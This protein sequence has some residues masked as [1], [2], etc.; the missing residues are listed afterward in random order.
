MGAWK[1]SADRSQF[2]SLPFLPFLEVVRGSFCVSAGEAK[3][4][5]AQKLEMGL[6]SLDL[7]SGCVAP[8]PQQQVDDAS[9][10]VQ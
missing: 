6:T 4:D 3:K 2:C 7:H 5:V 8:M 9:V 10:A 1:Q